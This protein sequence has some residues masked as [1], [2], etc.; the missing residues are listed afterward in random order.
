M[1]TLYK[2]SRDYKELYRIICEGFT[3]AVFVDSDLNKDV[4]ISRA[5]CLVRR[6]NPFDII[7]SSRGTIYTGVYPYMKDEGD[8]E[9]R[10]WDEDDDE[11]RLAAHADEDDDEGRIFDEDDDEGRNAADD[12]EDDEDSGH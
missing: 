1:K 8:E 11:S 3:V 6:H 4:K 2:L 12:D 9:G 5:I 10:L 7:V